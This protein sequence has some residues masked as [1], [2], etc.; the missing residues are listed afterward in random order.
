VAALG[1]ERPPPAGAGGTPTRPPSERGHSK[2]AGQLHTYFNRSLFLHFERPVGGGQK[3]ANIFSGAVQSIHSL[4]KL[5]QPSQGSGT[6]KVFADLAGSLWPGQGPSA[7]L[8]LEPPETVRPTEPG[9]G[10]T[11]GRARR[12]GGGAEAAR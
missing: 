12:D 10:G 8:Q 3:V 5:P 7:A 9:G 4:S 11:S 1:S 6:E 2:G